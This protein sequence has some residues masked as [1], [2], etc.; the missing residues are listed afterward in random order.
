MEI[1]NLFK[2]NNFSLF[3]CNFCNLVF[4]HSDIKESYEEDYFT[5]KRKCYYKNYRYDYD[6]NLFPVPG[7]KHILDRIKKTGISGKLLDIGCG[8]GIF[9]DL[10]R[11]AGFET[12]C[13]DTSSYITQYAKKYFN[14]NI[15]CDNLSNINFPE[16]SFD[17]ITIL[18][19]IEHV[20][21]PQILLKEINRLLKSE[22]LLVIVTPNEEALINKLSYAI[23]RLSGGKVK[24]LVRSNHAPEHRCYFSI[25]SLGHLL[26]KSGFRITDYYYNEID[27]ALMDYNLFVTFCA[28]VIFYLARLL[29]QQ[30]KMTIFAKKTYEN[31]H[32]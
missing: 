26:Q 32:Y 23:Y 25:E 18:D 29:R 28:R 31:Y 12:T 8:M 4:L 5:D 11:K 3:K 24:F 1:K 16:K 20:E 14:L 9:L 7:Y 17:V 21:Q 19:L 10:A 30:H 6:P 22:G 27:P 2:D 13:V 15:I